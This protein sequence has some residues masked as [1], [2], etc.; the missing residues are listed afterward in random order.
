VSRAFERLLKRAVAATLR[1]IVGSGQPATPLP[2]SFQRILVVRQ[3]N[4]LGDMLCAV[5]L[6]RALRSRFPA[7]RITLLASPVNYDVMVNLKYL[8]EVICFDKREFI[9]S[10]PRGFFRLLKFIKELRH[11]PF[12]LAIVP[13]TVSTSFTSDLIAY[14][15]G[16]PYRIGIGSFDLETSPSGFFFNLPVHARWLASPHRHQTLRN[17]DTGSPL[18]LHEKDLKLEMTL[19]ET[20][21]IAAKSWIANRLSGFASAIALHPGAGK[22]PNRWATE[23]FAKVADALTREF[24]ARIFVTCGPMDKSVVDTLRASVNIPLELIE[25]EPIR[26]V[27]SYLEQMDLLITNDTG[28]MHVAASV[29][30]PVLSIFGPTDPLQWAPIGEKNRYIAGKDGVIDSV[31]VEEVLEV[32]RDMLRKAR[33]FDSAEHGKPS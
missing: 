12:E 20:E 17:L 8:D 19:K 6:L 2:Q 10:G 28:I 16:A 9:Q 21:V 29:G 4:Q 26:R 18:E 15:A 11:K 24:N 30:T 14:L 5:P 13:S 23:H 32:A 25:N 3:H 27:A 22:V 1:F 31:S 7:A 33:H